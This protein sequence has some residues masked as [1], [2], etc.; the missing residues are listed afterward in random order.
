[1]SLSTYAQYQASG[2]IVSS[3][4]QTLYTEAQIQQFLDEATD[5][6]E[7]MCYQQL[8]DGAVTE[9]LTVGDLYCSLA[10]GGALNIFP[11]VSPINSITSLSYRLLPSETYTEIDSDMYALNSQGRVIMPY[12]V[13][14]PR[15]YW[16]EIELVYN[17]GY[18]TVPNDLVLANNLVAAH[19]ASGGYASI[20]NQG[21]NARKVVPDWAWGN[22]KDTK[23]IVDDIIDRYGRKF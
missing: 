3:P 15:G 11:K 6:L 12:A 1:M 14:I 7:S 22:G 21:N 5:Y 2:L 17:A 10:P 23:S 19:F 16:A 13:P 8:E 18:A 20:D 9:I 4:N